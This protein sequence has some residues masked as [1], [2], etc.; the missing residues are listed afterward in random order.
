[1]AETQAL[2]AG[3][4]ILGTMRLNQVS[5][6]I[7]EWVD[8][9]SAAHRLGIVK[10]HSSSEYETFPLLCEI[11]ANLSRLKTPLTFKHVVKLAEPSFDDNGFDPT[12]LISKVDEY[13]QLLGT[14]CIH[15]VQWMWRRGLDNDE[16]RV[17]AFINSAGALHSVADELKSQGKIERLICFPYSPKFADEAV[18]AEAIDGL[19]VYRNQHETE[20]DAAI[21]NCTAANKMVLV[22]RPL[23]AGKVLSSDG[24]TPADCLR[25]SLDMQAIEAGIIS[26]NSLCHLREFLR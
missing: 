5:R 17:A 4:L 25:F 21:S 26:S 7:A 18:R 24:K 6:S 13:R 11:L 23:N 3:H 22:I 9:F 12:R 15:D 2:K 16:E 8:Y 20:Y 19:A 1:M 10:L 14:D